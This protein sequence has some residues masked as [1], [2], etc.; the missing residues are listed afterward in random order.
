M[1]EAEQAFLFSPVKCV[2]HADLALECKFG[3]LSAV[4][5][6]GLNLR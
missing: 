4:E 6:R 2:G 5:N 3:R 1:S